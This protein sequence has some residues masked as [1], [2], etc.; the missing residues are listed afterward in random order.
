MPTSYRPITMQRATAAF[1]P[2]TARCFLEKHGLLM[3]RSIN[4]VYEQGN[5]DAVSVQYPLA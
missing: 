5:P 3:R 2:M 1:V 4:A